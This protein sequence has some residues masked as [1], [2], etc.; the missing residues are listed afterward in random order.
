[1]P[2]KEGVST[3]VGDFE[4]EVPAGDY[5]I[6]VSAPDFNTF[7]QAIKV[8]NGM[9]PLSVTL[10]VKEL[11][12]VVNVNSQSNEVG[13]DPESSLTTDVITGDALLDLPD[14]EDDLLAYL[15]QLAAARGIIDGE[16]NIR[17]DGFEGA[18]LPNRNEIQEI[19]I[20]NN[21]F[22]AESNASGPRIEIVTRPGTGNWTGQAGFTFNDSGLNARQ[23][24]TSSTAAKPNSQT[25]NFTGGARGPIIPGRI[26]TNFNVQHS[27]TDSDGNAILRWAR[28]AR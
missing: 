14:N 20:V 17:V 25:R 23:P 26:T 11:E 8:A 21:S 13:V 6:E 18:R 3:G 10:T 12:T 27:E 15:E 1:M 22:S 4:I 7:A 19:R 28:M 24:L 5:R 9:Q 16:L 2:T